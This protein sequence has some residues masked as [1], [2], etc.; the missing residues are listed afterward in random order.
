MHTFDELLADLSAARSR[1]EAMRLA[2]GHYGERAELLSRLHGLRAD[3]ARAR[4]ES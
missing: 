2:G 3:I 1:L 4:V